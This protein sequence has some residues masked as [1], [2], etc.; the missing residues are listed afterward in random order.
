MEFSFKLAQIETREYGSE[1]H[2]KL[3]N[4]ENFIRAEEFSFHKIKIFPR[5]NSSSK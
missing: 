2:K 5:Q 1:L 3:K 4:R